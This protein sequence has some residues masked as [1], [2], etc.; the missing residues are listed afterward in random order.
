[1]AS[2]SS[3]DDTKENAVQVSVDAKL[4]VAAGRG[5]CQQLKDLL[6]TEDSKTML[7]VMAP[8]IQ[9]STVKPL[10]EVMNPLLLSSACSGAWQDLEFLLNRGHGQPHPSMNSSTKFHDLLTAYGS[11]SCGNKGTSMQK[12]S[13]DVEALPNLPS[14]SAVSLLDGVTIEGGTALHVVATYGESDGFL[15]SADIIHSKAR[16]LLFARNKNGD[17]PLHCA[18]RAGMSRMVCHLITLARDENTGL[19][20]V[21]ELLE[22]EN[23]HKETALHQAVRIG[24]N[25]IVKLEE[26][27]E[28]ASFPKDGTSPLYLAI[29]LEEDII[30][31]TLYNASHMKLSYSGKNGQNAL[32]AAVLRGTELTKKLLEWNSDL[33]TQRDENGSTPLHFAAA[34]AQQ[35]QRGSICWQVLEA[36]S[37][38]LYQS[39]CNGLFP[40]HVAASVGE[41]G[42]ITMFLNKSPSSAGLQDSMGRTFLHVAAEKRKV[43][44]VSSACRNR[45][46]LWI[47]NI[48]DNDGN[49]AL[50][51]AIQARSLR[52]FCALLGNRHTHLNLSNNIGQTPLDISPYG[53]PPGF[54]D[55]QIS[56]AK[57]HFALTVVNARSG[58]SRRDHFEENY[59]RQLK[60]DETEQLEKAKE[61]TQTLCIGVALIATATFSVTFALPGGYK[62]DEHVN[63]G[64]PTLAGTYAFDAFI[65]ASTFSFV[66]SAMAMVCTWC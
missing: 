9:A 59:T 16:H 64:T 58:G 44:I 47:L 26:N 32:H 20:R 51:L 10:P 8:S 39:D 49:T 60:Y 1:M 48:Q 57:I 41:S 42:T 65:I 62:A 45:P 28:L 15:R 3:G 36:N 2:W 5:N 23:S 19:N 29:L 43:R 31:E 17:T 14:L 22:I 61:P 46:L 37:A 33:T 53:V 56:E 13:D 4:T 30:V 12:A 34:L 63:G 50:H 24:N 54:F 55:D 38:A 52:M 6:S 66:L 11:D 25:D 18:A 7:V 21:K 40:I 35:S 27:S